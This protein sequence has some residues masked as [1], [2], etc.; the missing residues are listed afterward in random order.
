MMAGLV[1]QHA[2]IIGPGAAPFV[3]VVIGL[4][5]A[6]AHAHGAQNEPP[7]P[8]GLQRL[9]RLDHRNVEAVLLDNKQL[10]ASFVAGADHVVGI[11]KPQRHWLFHDHMLSRLRAGDDM[12]G[13]H[14]TRRQ[15]RDRVDIPARQKVVDIVM[16]GDAELRSDGVRARANG[17][18]NGD[19]TGPVDMTAPQ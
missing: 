12:L 1:G 14:S 8:A 5:P 15:D 2:A 13:M 9:A 19:Q 3:L 4:V 18:A 16:D 10:D 6:P 7:E 17:I 11:L